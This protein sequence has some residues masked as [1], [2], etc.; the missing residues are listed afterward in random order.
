MRPVPTE[1]QRTSRSDPLRPLSGHRCNPV[2]VLVVVP[3]DRT[4]DFGG[5]R[6]EQVGDLDAAMMQVSDVCQ[7]A[8]HVEGTFERCIACRYLPESVQLRLDVVVVARISGR[9]D[10]LQADL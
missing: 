7:S 9:V 3:H 8:L 1:L 6:D 4:S 5:G 2:E 10:N